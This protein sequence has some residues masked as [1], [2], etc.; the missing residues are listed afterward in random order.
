[1]E[2]S[3]PEIN[4]NVEIQQTHGHAAL[5]IPKERLEAIAHEV[6]ET[7]LHEWGVEDSTLRT[8][9]LGQ[10]AQGRVPGRPSGTPI[11]SWAAKA[12]CS[13]LRLTACRHPLSRQPISDQCTDAARRRSLAKSPAVHAPNLAVS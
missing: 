7:G 13:P 4:I 10:H 9:I 6:V 1:M 5:N 8:V 3:D 12:T 2:Q 11:S